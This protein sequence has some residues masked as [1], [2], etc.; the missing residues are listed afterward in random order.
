M[1][2]K[3]L[4]YSIIHDPRLSAPIEADTFTCHR[5]CNVV[6]RIPLKGITDEIIVDGQVR[7]I[8]GWCHSHDAPLCLRCASY[9]TRTGQRCMHVEQWCEQIE[10]KAHYD[11]LLGRK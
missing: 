8:G 4:G 5:C 11:Q 6:D 3:A 2:R 10:A 9:L 7:P 1:K